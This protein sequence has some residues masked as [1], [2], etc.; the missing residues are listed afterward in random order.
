MVTD[1][2]GRQMNLGRL[3]STGQRVLAVVVVVLL[4]L[5]VLQAARTSQTSVEAVDATTG[6]QTTT[7]IIGFTQRESLGTAVVVERWLAGQSSRR[8]LQIARALL[9]RRLA[10]GDDRGV[11]AGYRSGKDYL[12]SLKALDA[13]WADAP[14]GVLPE[15]R[16]KDFVRTVGHAVVEFTEQ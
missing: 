14:P 2:V 4:V 16:R 10:P 7:S 1:D 3:F 8:D 12:D 5:T 11:T 15:D 6:A 9:A 13:A